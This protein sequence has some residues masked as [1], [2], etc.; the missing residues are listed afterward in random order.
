MEITDSDI[1]LIENLQLPEAGEKIVTAIM[2]SPPARRVKA[3]A[4]GKNRAVRFPSLKMGFVIQAESL[5]LE[6]AGIL[7]HEFNKKVWRFYDQPAHKLEL[8]YQSGS[9]NIHTENT[10][11]TFVISEDFVGFEEYKRRAELLSLS[12]KYTGHYYY[13]E[14]KK[15][16]FSRAIANALAGTGLSYRIITEDDLPSTL[17]KNLEYLKGYLRKAPSNVCNQKIKVVIELL[18]KKKKVHCSELFA[19]CGSFDAINYTVGLNKAFFPIED[20]DIANHDHFFL[21]KNEACYK[22]HAVH[23]IDQNRIFDRYNIPPRLLKCSPKKALEKA[24]LLEM[25]HKIRRGKITQK[26]AAIDLEISTRTIRRA[27]ADLNNLSPGQSELNVLI[28]KDADK[29]PPRKPKLTK[30]FELL[31]ELVKEV[32]DSNRCFSTIEIHRKLTRKCNAA[33]VR[34]PVENFVY[35]HLN[36][37]PDFQKVLKAQGQ[38]AAYQLSANQ[39]DQND[40]VFDFVAYRF[41]QLVHIDHTQIDLE[42]FGQNGEEC[43]KPWLTMIQD[44]YTGYI[45]AIYL[46]FDSPSYVAL[47]MALRGMIKNHGLICEA[48]LFDGGNEFKSTSWEKLLAF[49]VVDGHSRSGQPR[50][51]GRIERQFGT[52]NTTFFHNLLGNTKFMKNVRSVS[53]TH[54]PKNLAEWQFQHVLIA[55]N[56]Y[57]FTFNHECP[58]RGGLAPDEIR[59]S[60]EKQYG[61]REFLKREYDDEVH[62]LTLPISN[63]K[64]RIKRNKPV[65]FQRHDYWNDILRTAGKSN[66]PVDL[67]F[68]PEDPDYIFF[69]YDSAWHYAE[70]K[71]RTRNTHSVDKH[72]KAEQLR[73]TA[74]MNEMGKKIGYQK[75]SDTMEAISEHLNI[76]SNEAQNKSENNESFSEAEDSIES[77]NEKNFWTALVPASRQKD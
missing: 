76:K 21:Y 27:M 43:E 11:D 25:I 35:S 31:Q 58:F 65:C 48:L 54:L 59:A 8:L 6:F 19:V 20:A 71:T 4:A 61:E 50:V 39:I 37:I 29:G 34:P 45:L 51:G 68:D 3:S 55:M 62:F 72:Q 13:D 63:F 24:K 28:P 74:Y 1:E 75:I 38:K 36:K 42:V 15:R 64:P 26:Q 70:L 14:I 22:K 69:F 30:A 57:A 67:K 60:S 7:R 2:A 66:V 32:Q 5:T 12:K 40:S 23:G 46:S 44:D 73:H 52:L 53:K 47:M 49:L 41:L 9:R 33:G 10:L 18:S 56:A 17:I 77:V 16:F